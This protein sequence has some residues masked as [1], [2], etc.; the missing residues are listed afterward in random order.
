[1]SYESA[2]ILA[3]GW[4]LKSHLLK[5]LDFSLPTAVSD[6]RT[7]RIVYLLSCDAAFCFLKS[8]TNRTLAPPLFATMK[9]GVLCML[10]CSIKTRAAV[11]FVA[12]S[13]KACSLTTGILNC[14]TYIG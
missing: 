2:N 3:H 8:C 9:I 11:K 12:N 13:S 6:S 5:I 7:S 10:D 14:C 1:M 4:P